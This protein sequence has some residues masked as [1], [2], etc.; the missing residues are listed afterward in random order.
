[1]ELQD[2]E[3]RVLRA[4]TGRIDET[5]KSS[6]KK[7]TEEP[8]IVR[9][10]FNL[11]AFFSSSSPT[12]LYSGYLVASLG[13]D[14]SHQYGKYFDFHRRLYTEP[15][16]QTLVRLKR[17]QLFFDALLAA[18]E[19]DKGGFLII[20]G[21]FLM[22]RTSES[23]NAVDPFSVPYDQSLNKDVRSLLLRE[24]DASFLSAPEDERSK[25]YQAAQS[26]EWIREFCAIPLERMLLRF[27]PMEDMAQGCLLDSIKEEM[28]ILVG[29][30][31]AARKVPVLLLEA[32]FLFT[33]Q[34]E[35]L[36]GKFDIEGECKKFVETA[37]VHLGVIREVKSSVPLVDFVRYT[38]NDVAWQ[39]VEHE[40]GEDWFVLFK[41]AWKR[42]F[43]EKWAEWNQLHRRSMLEKSI[44]DYLGGAQLPLIQ[45]HP[46]N[47]LWMPLA[48]RHELSIQFLKGL[49]SV[50]YPSFIMKP[51]KILLIEGDF[52]R[53][54]NLV[55]YTDAFSALEHQQQVIEAF[56]TR[57]SEKGDFGE[58]FMIIQKERM[59]SIKGKARLENLMLSVEL[60][61]DAI[62]NGVLSAFRSVELIL[63]GVLGGVKGG[64][65]ETL[66]NMASIQGKFNE[67]YRKEL[68][69]VRQLIQSA[70]GILAEASVAQKDFL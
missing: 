12:R 56:E 47:G 30:F 6:E 24:M 18:Y 41:N 70:V 48:F 64:A 5:G 37:A 2:E 25:M 38:L 45:Y 68:Q 22:K 11:L 44:V 1:M 7:L 27:G 14:L 20:L 28:Q 52:Y 29:V 66:S 35:M 31:S 15:M 40:L 54:E 69:Y 55:E 21:S 17:T 46:W 49:F 61:A 9:L 42:R 67:R 51:L 23:I 43:D 53:R 8:F 26:I 39:P 16:F 62:V 36:D 57:L 50:V 32:L 13:R 3:I 4:E 58:G 33:K 65:Y 63:G 10:W 34:S 19:N 59:A 60:E